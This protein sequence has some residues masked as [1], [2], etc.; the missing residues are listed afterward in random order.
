MTLRATADID[1]DAAVKYE[2]AEFILHVHIMHIALFTLSQQI[3][4]RS[5]SLSASYIIVNMSPDAQM[6]KAEQKI[7]LYKL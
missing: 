2:S 4:S 3:K 1:K 5:E 6:K 7:L